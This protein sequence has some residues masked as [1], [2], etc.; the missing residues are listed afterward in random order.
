MESLIPGTT[1]FNNGQLVQFC[2]VCVTLEVPDPKQSFTVEQGLAKC[3]DHVRVNDTAVKHMSDENVEQLV[4]TIR[5][6]LRHL[7]KND[8]SV[9]AMIAQ[10]IRSGYIRGRLHQ[11]IVG[12]L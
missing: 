9:D 7:P 8:S 1:M 3:V 5:T 4:R 6:A 12:E 11:P 10:G 2:A